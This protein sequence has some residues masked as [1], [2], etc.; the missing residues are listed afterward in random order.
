MSTNVNNFIKNL[1]L[2]ATDKKVDAKEISA[3]LMNR[4]QPLD[5]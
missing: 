4:I 1:L 3:H 2:E 5:G